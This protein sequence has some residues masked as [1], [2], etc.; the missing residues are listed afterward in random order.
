VNNCEGLLAFCPT[1][2]NPLDTPQPKGVRI[3][4]LNL[5]PASNANERSYSFMASPTTPFTA[6]TLMDYSPSVDFRMPYGI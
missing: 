2:V 5:A 4:G 1:A 6:S 3:L